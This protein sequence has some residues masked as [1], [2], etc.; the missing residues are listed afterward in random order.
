MKRASIVIAVFLG[1]C[2]VVVL[3]VKMPRANHHKP[4]LPEIHLLTYAEASWDAG[5][6]QLDDRSAVAVLPLRTFDEPSA[7]DTGK[8][9]MMIAYLEARWE[10]EKITIYQKDIEVQQGKKKRVKCRE[11]RFVKD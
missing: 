5:M 9:G 6:V 3:L 7:M 2:S 4:P 10:P 8:L 11:Y 1:F